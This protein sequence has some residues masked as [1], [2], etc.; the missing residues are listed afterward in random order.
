VARQV[1]EA[2]LHEPGADRAGRGDERDRLH[3]HAELLDDQQ[4]DHREQDRLG[5]IDRVS[6]R[7]QPEREVR[8]DGRFGAGRSHG[9]ILT[10]FS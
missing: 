1:G 8:P 3:A 2:R 6:D 4:E 9:P 5:V 7:Q 10:E